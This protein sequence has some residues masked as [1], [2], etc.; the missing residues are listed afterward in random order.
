MIDR[1]LCLLNPGAFEDDMDD[2]VPS[3]QV[4]VF[5]EFDTEARTWEPA[6]MPHAL[7]DRRRAR[8]DGQPAMGNAV[9]D[10]DMPSD[11]SVLL[12]LVPPEEVE[13][14][15]PELVRDGGYLIF[16]D[17]YVHKY[18][19]SKVA[20]MVRQ[21]Q[22]GK[23]RE[24]DE[25]RDEEE[26]EDLSISGVTSAGPTPFSS[27]ASAASTTT[28]TTTTNAPPLLKSKL[29]QVRDYIQEAKQVGRPLFRQQ[30]PTVVYGQAYYGKRN[31][32][33]IMDEEYPIEYFI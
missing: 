28:T 18:P 5:E 29:Q 1:I 19:Q 3:P 20:D 12:E 15:A 4:H 2:T 10:A 26:E 23:Q 14:A 21:F 8:Y 30:D 17:D 31:F 32:H 13:E 9:V 33:A 11:L 16:S 6:E 24:I 7:P 22:G 25:Q 27:F